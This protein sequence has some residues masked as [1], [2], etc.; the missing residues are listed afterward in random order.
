MS[1]E[2]AFVRSLVRINIDYLTFNVEC[3]KV[4]LEL[5]EFDPV[6]VAQNILEMTSKC[7]R[8]VEETKEIVTYGYQQFLP[9]F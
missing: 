5:A 8:S 4:L 2:L 6:I 9:R 1:N 3:L 7:E